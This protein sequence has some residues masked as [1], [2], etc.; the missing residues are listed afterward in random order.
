MI[1]LIATISVK[2][3][4]T[5]PFEAA[6][7]ALVAKVKANEPGAQMYQLVKAKTSCD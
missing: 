7:H 5:G 2:P 6:A 1:A 4:K 3:D